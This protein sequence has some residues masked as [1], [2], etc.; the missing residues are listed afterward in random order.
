MQNSA[1]SVVSAAVVG[2]DLILGLS[3]GSM[4]NCGRVQGPQGL[5]GE[6]GPVGATGLPGIDGNTIHTVEG[7]PEQ[8]L[9]KDGDFAIDVRTWT[10]YGPRAGMQWG[11]GTPLRGRGGLGESR[12]FFGQAAP[13]SDS[14]G[15]GT[16]QTTMT[17]PLSNPTRISG[18]RGLP[19]TNGLKNQADYNAWAYD[20]LESLAAGVSPEV[21]LSG[22]AKTEDLQD[23]SQARET[24][25]QAN[26]ALIHKVADDLD[27]VENDYTTTDEFNTLN[28]K[29]S[30]NTKDIK[31]LQDAPAPE[32]PDLGSYA[33]KQDLSTATANLPYRLETDKVLRTADEP[34]KYN[35]FD[36]HVGQTHSGGEIQLVDNLGMFYNV[37]FTGEHGIETRSDAAGIF[38]DGSSLQNRIK[39]LEEQVE[40]LASLI[41]PVDYGTVTITGGNDYAE[42]QCWLAP[43][44]MGLFLC[45]LSGT[46]THG[47][48]YSW[49]L[50]RGEGRLSGSTIEQSVAL[51]C[52][53]QAPN[54]LVLR[55]T[56][57]HPATEEVT[58]G[59][60]TILVQNPD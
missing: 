5:T 50:M 26:L 25:D 9:G 3:D 32:A 48:R 34:Q 38:V 36:D 41:P 15:G 12:D 6:A 24:G 43:D 1:A 8:R 42:G 39:T 33:T 56:V 53:A 29:V 31:T 23:E 46:N 27:A 47:C 7:A 19:D 55:C 4:I 10:I 51:I 13:G 14:G 18:A 59:E 44:E 49:E 11:N 37:R 21:D 58:H 52:Q 16:M 22:Y 2:G 28:S 30:Q 35:A 45:E 57:T 54:T 17:L 60:I 20:A 40:I